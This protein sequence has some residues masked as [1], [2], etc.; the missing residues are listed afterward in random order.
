[1]KRAAALAVRRPLAVLGVVG[2]LAVLGAGLAVGLRPSAAADTLVGR[3]SPSFRATERYDR[4]FGD[5]AVVVLVR[6]QL[7]D[8]VLSAD[9]GRLLG[10]EGCLSGNLPPGVV[11]HG[12]P[13]GPCAEIAREGSTLLVFGPATFV[14]ESAGELDDQLAGRQAA[15]RAREREAANAAYRLAR[16]RR[17]GPGQ[18]RALAAQAVSLVRLEFIRTLLPLA[19]QYN[20]L[21]PPSL[22]D[23]DF[24]R[25]L[26]FDPTQPLGTPKARFSS[27][28]PARDAAVV[29]VRLRAGLSE[30]R[31]ARAID[32]VRR[33]TAMADWRLGHG[34]RYSVTGV[35]VI[36]TDLG[37]S[38]SR[39]LGLLLA[40]S[41]MVMAAT[42]G[43]V[44][45]SRPRLLPLAVALAAAALTFGALAVSGARLTMASV[46]VLPV[47]IGLAV[48]YAIQF[49]S[50]YDEVR[51]GE[52]LEAAAAIERAV[53]LGGPTIAAAAAATAGGF[54][55]LGLPV[56]GSPVPMVRDFGLLLVVGVGLAFVCAL[57]AGSAA[58]V[59]LGRRRA[60][61][62]PGTEP[63]GGRRLP[64]GRGVGRGAGAAVRAVGARLGPSLRG[65][66]ELAA[67]NRPVR[68][69]RA[70]LGSGAR[71]GAGR[72]LV[73]RA[74]AG[75]L[76]AAMARPGRV[77][78]V[79]A[80]LAVVG[81][82]VGTQTR[83]ESDI[84]KLV[85]QSLPALRD[86]AVLQASTHVGGEIDVLVSG[87]DLTEPSVVAWMTGYQ[88]R[89]EKRFGYSGTRGC[90]RAVLCPAFSLPDLFQ[91]AGSR[92]TGADIRGLLG[93]VPA[94]FSREVITADRRSAT[95]A[96]G[97]RLMALA[98][99]KRVI[100]AMRAALDPP[101]GVRAEL[102]GLPV[103]AADANARIA[104]PWGRLATLVAGLLAVG[105][106]LAAGLR[107]LR[108]ALVPLVP[109]VLATGWSALV[110]FATRVPLNPMSVTLGALVV[111]IATEFSVLLA[112]RYRQER[113]AGRDPS[114]ALER[115]YR[116]TGAAVLASGA[117]AIAGF[118]VLALSDIRM[119][120]DF[121][122][123]TVVDLTVALVGVLVAL[124][125]VLVLA[126]GRPALRRAGVKGAPRG[127]GASGSRRA[128]DR[129]G[130]G[131]QT[132]GHGPA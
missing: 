23:P 94:Y 34:G 107:S 85:P 33:A 100:D 64:G 32:L 113:S 108:R 111:A 118:G 82:G 76:G 77:L 10:L 68:A 29:Q 91:T 9:I 86:L 127:T 6:E 12:G 109:I 16:A 104:S 78:G 102:V 66:R 99:Q 22:N 62:R 120:R 20:L 126:E 74:G 119:L 117:T 11:P 97:I 92:P 38:V 3:S 128:L 88:G 41:L 17:A 101:A 7:Q 98:E 71:G 43:L 30:A 112:E 4:L 121:G 131:G 45:R 14:N 130:P 35:P 114:A 13:R 48:D 50:R 42:L 103:L 54:L 49:Q 28:F 89:M 93:A 110:L 83:V 52:G 106:V 67:E 115:T 58:L 15:E 124:P 8:L 36:V 19:A 59:L 116:S 65:A 39:A 84:Q 31:R 60:P 25:T 51:R 81:W 132:R 40:A 73:G 2:M 105:L 61:A 90:G 37:R 69:L 125:A 122:L 63:G 75:A 129:A 53:L 56:I 55:V 1:M 24:V 80:A 70:L 57:S 5:D 96:F 44:F 123:V 46:G 79:A 95:L 26:V 27:L 47:L 18:A 72:R 87:A 21:R